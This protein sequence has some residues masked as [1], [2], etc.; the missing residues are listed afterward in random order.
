[1]VDAWGSSDMKAVDAAMKNIW[2]LPI[3]EKRAEPREN[4]QLLPGPYQINMTA[5]AH[6]IAPDD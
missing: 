1:M 5:S 2:G 3:W 4:F 6:S